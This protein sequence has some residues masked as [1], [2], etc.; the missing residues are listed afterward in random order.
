MSLAEGPWRDEFEDE[1]EDGDDEPRG[2]RRETI[3]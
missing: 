2:G 3:H 1:F